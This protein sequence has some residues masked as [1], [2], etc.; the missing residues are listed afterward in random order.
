LTGDES[1]AIEHLQTALDRGFVGVQMPDPV[2][3]SVRNDERFVA[4]EVAALQRANE[5]RAKLGI[6]PYEP[7]I[8]F[9]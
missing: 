1:A 6:D 8:Q 3:D 4:I 9:N 7:P 2:L 5:E